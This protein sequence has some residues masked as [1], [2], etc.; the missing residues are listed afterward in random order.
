MNEQE[1]NEREPSRKNTDESL[2]NNPGRTPGKA[3]GEERDV[4]TALKNEERDESKS[5]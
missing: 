5:S 1:K 2:R 3:E 4:E